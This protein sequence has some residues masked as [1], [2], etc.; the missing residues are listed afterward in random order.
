MR[1][2]PEPTESRATIIPTPS[3]IP[4]AVAIV[5]ALCRRRLLAI[6]PA[7]SARTLPADG[8]GGSGDA[9]MSE[10]GGDLSSIREILAGRSGE[11]MALNDR[12]LNPQLGRIVRTLGF[13]RRW[14]RR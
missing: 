6:S 3:A 5:R 9:N 2:S 7:T 11:E 14:M 12:Y 13:D 10:M 4:T 8:G 1:F